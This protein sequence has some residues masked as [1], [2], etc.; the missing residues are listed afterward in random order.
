MKYFLP[1]V[2]YMYEEEQRV[3]CVTW[4]RKN[5]TC[6]LD[7]RGK[8]HLISQ[9]SDTAFLLS[10]IESVFQFLLQVCCAP[11]ETAVRL[12]KQHGKDIVSRLS[13]TVVL[14]HASR[15]TSPIL[16]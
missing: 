9:L 16:L 13:S 3:F 1:N 15:H 12:S 2:E 14:E 7:G 8:S 10:S 6:S 11:D 4:T 5:Y